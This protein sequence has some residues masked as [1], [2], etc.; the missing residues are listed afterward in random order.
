MFSGQYTT[1]HDGLKQ[2]P[3]LWNLKIKDLKTLSQ[4]PTLSQH[5]YRIYVRELRQVNSGLN[6]LLYCQLLLHSFAY[7]KIPPLSMA[8]CRPAQGSERSLVYVSL[9]N[10]DVFCETAVDVFRGKAIHAEDL[11]S[12]KQCIRFPVIGLVP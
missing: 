12:I 1:H 8:P 6:A 7:S 9:I 2:K 5:Q 3:I 11:G 4:E 10:L